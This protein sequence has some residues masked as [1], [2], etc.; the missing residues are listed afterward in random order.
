M[1]AHGARFPIKQPPHSAGQSLTGLRTAIDPA[2]V[3]SPVEVIEADRADAEGKVYE[4]LPGTYVPL[5]TTDYVALDQG[6]SSPKFIRVS[7]WNVPSTSRLQSDCAIPLVSAV[8]PLVDQDPGEEPVPVVQTGDEGPARCGRCRAYVNAWCK[9]VSGGSKWKCNLCGHETEVSPSYFCNLDHNLLRLD[10]LQRPELN[11]GTVD[12]DVTSS[13]A[14]WATDPPRKIN[15]GYFSVD[16]PAEDLD[17][18]VGP[19]G[20]K[21][22]A[23]REPK[24][25]RFMFLL[26]ASVASVKSGFLS[27]GCEMIKEMLYGAPAQAPEQADGAP[28]VDAKKDAEPCFPSRAEIAI[29]TF[30]SALH[31]YN[32][33]STLDQA[34]ML[35]VPDI[36]EVFVPLRDGLFV[37][38][39]E[40]RT[41]IESLLTA[42]P[43]RFADFPSSDSALGAALRASQASLA[44]RG[45]HVVIFQATLPTVGPGT[46]RPS[47]SSSSAIPVRTTA[48]ESELYDTDKEKTLFT[49]RDPFW[50]AVGEECAEEGIGVSAFL[51]MS[52]YG[53]VASIGAVSSLS[54]GELFFHPRFDPIRDGPAM[55][56]QLRRLLTRTIGYNCMFRARCSTG[57]S[58]SGYL[59]NFDR[60]SETDIAFG[61][62]DADKSF[63]ITFE[64]SSSR[65]K[66]DPREHAYLQCALLYTTVQGERRVRTI[67]VALQVADLAGTVFRYADM[68][69]V[70]CYLAKDCISQMTSTRMSI[71]RDDL[72]ERCATLLLG[73]RRNCAASTAPTQ[74][75]L[76]EAFKSLPA[77]AL[78]IIKSKPLKGRNV[79][80]DVR[81]YHAHKI[82]G[83]SVRTTMQHL[84]P[85]MLALHDLDDTIALPDSD[86]G[87]IA[88]PSLM[89][90]TYMHMEASGIYLIDNEEITMIWIG[91]SASPQLLNDLFGTSELYAL[92][93]HMTSLPELPTRISMQVRNILAEWRM[94]RGGREPKFFL[95]RQNIDGTEV[96]FSDMLVEDQNNAAMSY[97]DCQFS[98]SFRQ[99]LTSHICCSDLRVVH[100]QINIGLTGGSWPGQTNMRGTPW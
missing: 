94:R 15:P 38:P 42:I 23:A 99:S 70:V 86:N 8:Q 27:A 95:A 93:P 24:P 79:S 100:K 75:I 52:E 87:R 48:I 80:S 30:D 77:Y 68:E 83:M 85:R 73:Y 63:C 20:G 88:F 69:T 28:S 9:F 1:Y 22:S 35:V 45:G 64:H 3:P 53:D 11:K 46:P 34:S 31:F 51:G 40:S 92:D 43:A 10:H 91:G 66:L 26:D 72:T 47:P 12:F 32:L 89:R 19:S 84:Y 2:H 21:T 54:G 98:L 13:Q 81:N 62:I 78:G 90:A 55:K 39:H 65:V 56:S 59:G 14:Y 44:G 61:T 58:V 4:T 7:T 97:I 41:A 67:N 37:D 6:N 29:L 60:A 16:A 25:M 74:L 96:E 57:L 50:G 17:L 33:S 36:E 49:P 5:S 71:I 82:K 76:P 18:V